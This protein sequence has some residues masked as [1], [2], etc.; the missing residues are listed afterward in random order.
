MIAYLE[1]VVRAK[2]DAAL[3][4]LTGGVGYLVQVTAPTLMSAAVGDTV[5]LHIET[6]VS[7]NTPPTL[8]GV[9]NE[10]DLTLLSALCKVQ[11]IGGKLAL[12]IVGHLGF[13]GFCQAVHDEDAKTLQSVSGVGPGM[14]KRLIPGC[15]KFVAA[16][17]TPKGA[18]EL[19]ANDR[20]D[21]IVAALADLG[22]SSQAVRGT[23]EQVV[24]SFPAN[25]EFHTLVGTCM[26]R[27]AAPA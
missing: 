5:S 27:V 11:G 3:V 2:R 21:R 19:R 6:K 15:E 10:R 4:V 12:T 7:E 13:D 9:E 18:T 24:G 17:F 16:S 25:T 1:G 26:T 8:Y 14:A 20:I 22:F 23:V